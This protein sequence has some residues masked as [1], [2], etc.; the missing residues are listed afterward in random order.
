MGAIIMAV[1]MAI[2]MH[3]GALRHDQMEASA[4]LLG[5]LYFQCLCI[6]WPFCRANVYQVKYGRMGPSGIGISTAI[7]LVVGR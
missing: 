1:C 7:G 6:A 4:R 5:D 3:I 2:G